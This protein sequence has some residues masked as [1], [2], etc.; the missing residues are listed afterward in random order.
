M[1]A[2][3]SSKPDPSTT[4]I[5][6]LAVLPVASLESAV[7]ASLGLGMADALITRLGNTRQ[8]TWG[9]SMASC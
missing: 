9:G 8:I 1:P 7:D 3:H 4:A 5:K 2:N 6:T